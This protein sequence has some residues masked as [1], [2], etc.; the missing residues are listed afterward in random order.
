MRILIFSNNLLGTQVYAIFRRI[1]AI[2]YNDF[3]SQH[4]IYLGTQ[5]NISFA[6]CR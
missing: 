2:E 4:L 6:T 1:N 5:K 3:Q